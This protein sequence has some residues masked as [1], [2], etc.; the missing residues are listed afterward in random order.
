MISASLP[1]WHR[2]ADHPDG[3]PWQ[4]NGMA[5]V[6][7]GERS[8]CIARYGEGFRAFAQRCPHAGALLSEGWVDPMGRVVCPLHRYRFDIMRGRNTSGEGYHLKTYE[9]RVDA[10]GV[11]VRA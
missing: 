5:V 1:T 3:L 7:A 8:V 11:Y 4:P 10:D 6:P 2:V 9:L